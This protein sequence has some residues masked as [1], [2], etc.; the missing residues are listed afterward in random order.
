[1]RG[2]CCIPTVKFMQF[3]EETLSIKVLLISQNAWPWKYLF[4]Q[5]K[6]TWIPHNTHLVFTLTSIQTTDPL[7]K[8]LYFLSDPNIAR[9]GNTKK[10]IVRA[11]PGIHYNCHINKQNSASITFILL[12]IFCSLAVLYLLSSVLNDVMNGKATRPRNRHV[13]HSTQ[14]VKSSSLICHNSRRSSQSRTLVRQP[15]ELL[16]AE[17]QPITSLRPSQK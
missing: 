11:C 6:E 7:W 14:W 2:V 5:H 8:I 1:M 9:T 15:A 12:L 4:I 16:K 10:H 3:F 17:D 13:H